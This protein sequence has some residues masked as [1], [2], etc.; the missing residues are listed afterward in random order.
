VTYLALSLLEYLLTELLFFLNALLKLSVVH[1][2]PD[3]RGRIYVH[4]QSLSLLDIFVM[5]V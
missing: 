2:R 4:I 5:F 1:L 3:S